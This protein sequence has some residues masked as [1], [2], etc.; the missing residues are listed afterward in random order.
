M[1]GA[2]LHRGVD[3]LDI[4]N[5]FIEGVNGLIDHRQQNAVDDEGREVFGI[6][7][8]LPGA[9]HKIDG[10]IESIVIGRDPANDFDKLHHRR[11]VHEVQADKAF[12][13]VG[14]CGKAGNGDRRSV[15]RDHRI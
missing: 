13:P 1:V 4:R 14:R 2:E 10:G 3:G 15:G 12:R 11:R 7:G 6:G 9:L 8:R 5:P